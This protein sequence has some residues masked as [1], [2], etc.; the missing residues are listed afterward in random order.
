MKP[1]LAMKKFIYKEIDST[2]EEIKKL[3]KNESPYKEALLV[4]ADKQNFGKGRFGRTWSSPAGKGIYMSFAQKLDSKLISEPQ[5]L[6]ELA[7]S[8]TKRTGL[9]LIEV[10]KKFFNSAVLEDLYL[11]PIN[12]I[13]YQEKKLAGILIEII[14]HN[15]EKFL[16]TG[17]GINLFKSEY[18]LD[19]TSDGKNAIPISLEEIFNKQAWHQSFNKT[20]LIES[21]A[22]ALLN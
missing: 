6:I 14:T 3:L 13:Y 21:I 2:Q 17:I 18:D 11:K 12:D 22:I 10:L 8:I 19:E 5:S 7:E 20:E 9:L 16:I 4:F 15:E 1:L